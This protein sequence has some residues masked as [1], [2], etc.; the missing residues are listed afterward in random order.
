M[1]HSQL[2]QVSKVSPLV[3]F[4]VLDHHNR[5]LQDQEYVI[6]V[7]LGTRTDSQGTFTNAFPL[8][9]TFQDDQLVIDTESMNSMYTLYQQ[10]QPNEVIVGWYSTCPLLEPWAVWVHG[11]FKNETE[12]FEPFYMVVN[13]SG[14]IDALDFPIQLY[15]SVLAGVPGGDEGSIFTPAKLDISVLES[16]QSGCIVV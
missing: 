6:G 8:H 4:S 5:R 13:P 3:L 7:L 9:Y 10:V 15:T 16:E 11:L 14:L 12:P 2:S 1:L